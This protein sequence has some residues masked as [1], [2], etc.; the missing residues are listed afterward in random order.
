MVNSDLKT[1]DGIKPLKNKV[2]SDARKTG[3]PKNGVAFTRPSP[4]PDPFDG[5]QIPA[6]HALPLRLDE[7]F[8]S[9]AIGP[10]E[11]S[12]MNICKIDSFEPRADT[13]DRTAARAFVGG[14]NVLL[15]RGLVVKVG[16]GLQ[17]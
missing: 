14:A 5:S 16:I 8:C 7:P 13:S 3:T 17:G 15:V 2:Y 1:P 10:F 9:G 6:P 4:L 11:K 12:A